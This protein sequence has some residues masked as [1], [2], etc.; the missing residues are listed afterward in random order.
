MFY[1]TESKPQGWRALA[2]FENGSEFLIFVGRSTTQIRA[3]YKEAFME[4]LDEE[5]RA[6][7][8]KISLQCWDGAPDRGRWVSK[9]VLTIPDRAKVGV[10]EMA[11][12]GALGGLLNPSPLEDQDDGVLEDHPILPFSRPVGE[13]VSAALLKRVIG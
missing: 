12:V 2:V 3:G 8:H 11:Q 10:L 13:P 5:E 4:L 6:Q 7:V 9:G 1:H